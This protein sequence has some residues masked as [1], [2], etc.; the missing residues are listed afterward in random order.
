MCEQL[1]SFNAP[2]INRKWTAFV[3]FLAD[4]G[5]RLAHKLHCNYFPK[6]HLCEKYYKICKQ[7]INRGERRDMLKLQRVEKIQYQADPT[8]CLLGLCIASKVTIRYASRY[9]GHDAIRIKIQEQLF[10][11]HC[12]SASISVPQYNNTGNGVGFMLT[13]GTIF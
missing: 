6:W 2:V 9:R 7:S 8:H 10:I 11:K 1:H 3:L 5:F 12:K 4:L 13:L